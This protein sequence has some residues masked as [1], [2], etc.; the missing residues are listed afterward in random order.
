MILVVPVLL[1]SVENDATKRLTCVSRNHANMEPA[2]IACFRTNVFANPDGLDLLAVSTSTTAKTNRVKMMELVSTSLTDSRA[3]VNQVTRAKS[4]SIQL[5]T[6][7]AIHAKTV[8]LA[9]TRSMD[10]CANA[11]RDTLVSSANRK[12]TNAYWTLAARSELNAASTWTTD[13]SVFVVTDLP[14]RRATL[15]LMTA[16]STLA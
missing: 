2:S 15:T 10:T 1:D 16:N 7:R 12:S 9:L 8:R 5:T 14:A 4:A 13:S 3:T 6:A 11:G